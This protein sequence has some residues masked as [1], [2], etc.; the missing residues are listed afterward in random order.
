MVGTG[1]ISG[2]CGT[3][4]VRG[5]GVPGQPYALRIS[6][7]SVWED[8]GTLGKITENMGNHH[9]PLKNPIIK[10]LMERFDGRKFPLLMDFF[11]VLK[12]GVEELSDLVLGNGLNN[13]FMD[14]LSDILK[15]HHSHWS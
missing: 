12:E 8:W 14:D 6:K 4:V 2:G 1:A 7:D 5:G 3:L 10:M 13:C 9:L 11:M 15:F